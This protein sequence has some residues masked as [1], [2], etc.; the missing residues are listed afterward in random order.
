M[1][2]EKNT[3]SG[4]ASTSDKEAVLIGKLPP[5]QSRSTKEH[6]ALHLTSLISAPAND[7]ESSASSS[8]GRKAQ[9]PLSAVVVGGNA[10]ILCPL[11]RFFDK[12][13]LDAAAEN[14]HTYDSVS[15]DLDQSDASD[16]KA[17]RPANNAYRQFRSA[18]D[19]PTK[20]SAIPLELAFENSFGKFRKTVSPIHNRSV[21]H[22]RLN[23]RHSLSSDARCIQPTAA[24]LA[25]IL[26]FPRWISSTSAAEQA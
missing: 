18:V 22:N 19:C 3:K 12:Q 5:T 10:T 25:T 7:C 23:L 2:Q 14:C 9:F 15:P 20:I 26:Q 11:V 8:Y 13:I 24:L 16:S 6:W 4:N 17:S 21:D 1:C